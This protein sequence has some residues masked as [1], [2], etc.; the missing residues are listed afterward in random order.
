MSVTGSCRK[1]RIVRNLRQG[2]FRTV[3]LGNAH[4]LWQNIGMM[5]RLKELRADKGWTQADVAARAGVS[6]SH[7]SD[8]ERGRRHPSTPIL[9]ALADLYGVSV[10]ELYQSSSEPRSAAVL[11][12]L[13]RLPHDRL[14]LVEQLIDRLLDDKNDQ[15]H[16]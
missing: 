2:E 6:V 5:L 4:Q 10:P 9:Q 11:R 1:L 13:E 3:R 7:I 8:M 15:S 12:K 16:R 14:D